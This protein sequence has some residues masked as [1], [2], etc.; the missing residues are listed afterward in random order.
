MLCGGSVEAVVEVGVGGDVEVLGD[1]YGGV[2]EE[3]GDVFVVVVG[4]LVTEAVDRGLPAPDGS[5]R[6]LSA[7]QP[8]QRFA[9]LF[10]DDELWLR[11][12]AMAVDAGISA[13]RAVGLLVEAAARRLVW[14]GDER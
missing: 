8:Q 6:E 7:R 10:L 4:Q 1:S 13:K 9:R 12:R 11:F 5:Q 3:A 2:A 14:P